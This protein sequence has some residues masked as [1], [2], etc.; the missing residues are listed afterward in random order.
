MSIIVR[1]KRLRFFATTVIGLEDIA[2]EEVEKLLDKKAKEDIGRIVFEGGITDVYLLNLK[3]RTINKLF[4]QLCH[5]K[6][7][8]LEDIYK[9][10]KNLDY[11][12]IINPEQTFAVRTQRI[13]LHNFTSI[14]VSRVVGQAIIDS[15]TGTANK[16]LKVNLDAPDVEVYCLVRDNEFL[17]GINTTGESLH[18]RHYRVYN[19][20][21]A[22]KST[23]ASAMLKIGGWSSDKVLLDPMCGGATIPIEAV[24]E[25]KR[26]SPG[27]WRNNF[28]FLRLK[29]YN[30][31][32]FERIK[33]E[34]LAEE[35]RKSEN[36][37]TV[38][39]ME[40]FATHIYGGMENAKKAGVYETINFKIGD[41]TKAED[42][43]NIDFDLIVVNPPYG[44]RANPKEGVRKLYE[45][46]LQTLKRRCTDA[47]L[48]LITAASKRFK[49]TAETVGVTVTNERKIWYGKL[50]TSIFTCKV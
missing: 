21:A 10:A 49:E 32:E 37:F 1:M 6:F 48:I 27:K 25:A 41:A 20:P 19:H 30:Q 36:R 29:L 26:V 17:M 24:L 45:N 39:A 42:Y 8:N 9:L 22:L 40:K 16:R 46:F 34:V 3:A 43:P 5:S 12:W 28:A 15:Y 7:E 38:Y 13:G 50:L 18:K 31:D 4:I 47:T 33:A 35:I 14:D 23:I 11:M 2:A 44:L